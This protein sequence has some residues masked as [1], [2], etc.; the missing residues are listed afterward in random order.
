MKE[1]LIWIRLCQ[2][3]TLSCRAMGRERED[4]FSQYNSPSSPTSPDILPL[5]N[6]PVC[7]WNHGNNDETHKLIESIICTAAL[8]TVHFPDGGQCSVWWALPQNNI[9]RL[10]RLI[11]GQ[12]CT[13]SDVITHWTEMVSAAKFPLLHKVTLHILSCLAH[14]TS[15]YLHCQQWTCWRT[16][17][18]SLMNTCISISDWPSHHWCQSSKSWQ[19]AQDATSLIMQQS[20]T[21]CK[22]VLHCT[23]T[24]EILIYLFTKGYWGGVDF[25]FSEIEWKILFYFIC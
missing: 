9:S 20:L 17:K 7:P 13:E 14:S 3:R 10:K 25:F 21:Q 22:I 11:T 12:H 19:Q 2:C 8:L 1:G 15:V 6:S 5:H 18:V 16:S 4:W 23:L 24:P